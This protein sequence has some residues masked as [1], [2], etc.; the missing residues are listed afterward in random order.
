MTQDKTPQLPARQERF[1]EFVPFGAEDKIKLSIDMVKNLVAVKTKQGHSCSD[2]DAIKFI[3]MCQ[4][5]RLNPF[6]GDAFLIGY[7]SKD[8]PKFTLVTAHQ[9]FLKRAE[10]HKEYDGMQSGLIV[11]R[12]EELMDITGDF[13]LEGDELLGG[14]ATVYFKTRTHP[15]HKR[16]RLKRFMKPFGIWQ[17]DP[18]GMIVKCAEADSLR[19]SFPTMLGG[20][21]T[22]E[23]LEQPEPKLAKPIFTKAESKMPVVEVKPEPVKPA[24]KPEPEGKVSVLLKLMADDKI[25]EATLIEFLEAVGLATGKEKSMAEFNDETVGMVIEQWPKFSKNIL[26]VMTSQS[27]P[28][29]DDQMELV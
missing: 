7:D 4:A 21:Y 20:L 3:A 8:G 28:P 15:M 22:R 10:L 5:R 6:E 27:A 12:G 19:S 9:A 2:T 18:A 11:K 17:E 1:T 16:V 26:D 14:W 23:E 25:P 24:P 13:Y 29:D